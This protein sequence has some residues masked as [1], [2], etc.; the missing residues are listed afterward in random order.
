MPKRLRYQFISKCIN[1]KK[2]SQNQIFWNLFQRYRQNPAYTNYH[3]MTGDKNW[4]QNTDI[5]QTVKIASP[6]H[7]EL[8]INKIAPTLCKLRLFKYRLKRTYF[9]PIR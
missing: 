4:C 2:K 3:K 9:I 1:I 7:S 8:S 5:N 6:S